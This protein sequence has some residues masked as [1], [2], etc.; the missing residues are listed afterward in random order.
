M[1]KKPEEY[2]FPSVL[3]R[4]KETRFLSQASLDKLV[5]AD[6]TQGMLKALAEL[7][8]GGGLITDKAESAEAAISAELKEAYQTVFSVLTDEP[9]LALFEYPGDYHNLKVLLKSQALGLDPK[10]L[11]MDTGSIEPE[12]LEEI[13]RKKEMASLSAV[14][15]EAIATAS[16]TFAKSQDPQEI[17]I[18]FD[19][20]CY[21]DMADAAAR[22]DDEFVLGYVRLLIDCLNMSSMIR[23]RRIGKGKNFF[24]KIFLSGGELDLGMFEALYEESYAQIADKLAPFGYY[25]IFTTGTAALDAT[26]SYSE[27]EKILDNI[28]IDYVRDSRYE[29]F[30]LCVACAYLVAK[31][32]EAKNIRII[33]AGKAAGTDKQVIAERLRRTYV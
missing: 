32:M 20:A 3:L 25:E 27:L 9:E 1:S 21:Q 23:L 22:L 18:I 28:K 6:G 29:P 11:L 17:D 2:I 30:G 26:G 14:M 19:R 31:E 7:G 4:S 33:L 12:K 13:V 5:E 15:K 24:E 10:D 8:Y 16:E